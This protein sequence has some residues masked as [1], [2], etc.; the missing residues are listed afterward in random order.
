MEPN[1]W[2][3]SLLAAEREICRYLGFMSGGRGARGVEAE[4]SDGSLDGMLLGVYVVD[5]VGRYEG[6]N[7]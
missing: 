4:A 1:I 2:T 3:D 6:C 7:I 5:A